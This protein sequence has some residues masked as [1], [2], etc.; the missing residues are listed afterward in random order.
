MER[1]HFKNFSVAG[2]SYYDGV[3]VFNRL[4]IGT[5]LELKAEPDNKYDPMAV[6]IYYGPYKLGFVPRSANYSLAKIL[7]AGY[8]IFETRVQF[9]NE[10]AMPEDQ[11]GVVVFIK[12]KVETKAV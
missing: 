10:T 2:F 6:A 4:K 3:L 9:V 5:E 11:L 12:T 7:T 8:N 1:I